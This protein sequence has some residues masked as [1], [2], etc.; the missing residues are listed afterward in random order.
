MSYEQLSILNTHLLNEYHDAYQEIIKNN[1]ISEI[2]SLIFIA[3][4]EQG[5]SEEEISASI[6]EQITKQVAENFLIKAKEH[7]KLNE[8]NNFD[9][10]NAPSTSTGIYHLPF[11][12]QFKI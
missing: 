2:L 3:Y 12:G 6:K 1:E 4:S 10:E 11:T 8:I 9:F 5:F 7:E